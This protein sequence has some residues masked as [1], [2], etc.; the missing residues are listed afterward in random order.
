MGAINTVSPIPILSDAQRTLIAKVKL[1]LERLTGLPITG[2]NIFQLELEHNGVIKIPRMNIQ[3][4]SRFYQEESVI[5][6]FESKGWYLVCTRSRGALAGS[7]WYI[8]GNDVVR[9]V[10]FKGAR[11][12]GLLQSKTALS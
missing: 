2:T 5:A 4:G 10:E 11:H 1:Y 6:I 9:V 12:E 7:P 8:D 3:I